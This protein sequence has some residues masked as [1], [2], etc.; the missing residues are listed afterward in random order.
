[1]VRI[2]TAYVIAIAAGAAW[3]GVGPTTDR[4]WLDTLVADVVATLVIFTASRLHRNSS[5]YDAYWS[6]IPPLLVAYW[7]IEAPDG[8][9]VERMAMVAVL[10]AGWAIRLTANWVRTFPG[11]HHEDWRYPLLRDGAGRAEFAVDLFAIHLLPTGQVFLA[12]VP[13]Y[14]LSRSQEPLGPLD[15]VAFVAGVGAVV[16]EAMADRQMHAF[17]DD[18]DRV[19]GAVMDRGLWGW[20]RHPN[21]F[22]E[23]SFWAAL[24]IFGLAASDGDWRLVAGVL[25]MGAMFLGASIPM[26]ERRS[27]ERRP[28]YQAV[29]D[30][31][32]MLVPWPPSGRRGPIGDS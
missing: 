6:V 17:R 30:R 24:A 11:L 2:L 22:G 8:V 5:F 10:V 13:V 9:T 16:I 3:L 25:A 19:D 26:M 4:L 29:I 15:G 31:V 23:L 14:V 18:P 21:Y 7:W 28:E 27:L 12:M 20:S 32:P 1:M